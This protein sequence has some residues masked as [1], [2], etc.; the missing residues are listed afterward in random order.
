VAQQRAV[1][2]GQHRAHPAPARREELMAERVDT[3]PVGDQAPAS[4]PRADPLS[5][6]P[7]VQQLPAGDNAVLRLR[8]LSHLVN[9]IEVSHIDT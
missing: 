4:P 8:K 2:A 3:G 5:V 9:G 7:E 1:A 6:K